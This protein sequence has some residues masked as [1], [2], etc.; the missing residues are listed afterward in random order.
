M[1]D[2]ELGG[3]WGFVEFNSCLEDSIATEVATVRLQ[4]IL[5]WIIE[6]IT[7][8]IQRLTSGP[9]QEC[10][11]AVSLG[12]HLRARMRLRYFDQLVLC[13]LILSDQPT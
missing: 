9:H 6:Q 12:L 10:R 1:K 4:T 5:A 7:N 13:Q 11:D 3:G 2:A 8:W